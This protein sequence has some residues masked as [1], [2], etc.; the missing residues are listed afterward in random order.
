ML[1]QLRQC[2]L[3]LTGYQASPLEAIHIFVVV[4]VP[5]PHVTEHGEVAPVT[6]WYV[7]QDGKER[8][9]AVVVV[10]LPHWSRAAELLCKSWTG[11]GAHR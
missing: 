5:V 8:H 9:G 7:V 6:H 1:A 2:W 11:L 4:V 10:Q 3:L